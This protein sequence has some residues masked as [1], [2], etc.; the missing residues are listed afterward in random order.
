MEPFEF[1]SNSG[2]VETLPRLVIKRFSLFY[3]IIKKDAACRKT[4]RLCIKNFISITFFQQ[5]LLLNI[6]IPK[7]MMDWIRLEFQLFITSIAVFSSALISLMLISPLMN[8]SDFDILFLPI[9][10]ISKLPLLKK[11]ITPSVTVG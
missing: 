7:S 6:C 2:G 5:S 3:E 1:I 10:T 9:T 8:S 11:S 4:S